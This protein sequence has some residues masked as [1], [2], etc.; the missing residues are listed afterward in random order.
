MGSQ[1]RRLDRYYDLG[2]INGDSRERSQ[3]DQVDESW[4]RVHDSKTFI[5]RV[6]LLVLPTPARRRTDT[7]KEIV[8]TSWSVHHSSK[9]REIW[10]SLASRPVRKQSSRSK[11]VLPGE[12]RAHETRS[13]AKLW[14]RMERW[15]KNWLGNGTRVSIGRLGKI[16]LSDSGRSLNSHRVSSSLQATCTCRSC[17]PLRWSHRSSTFLWFLS[18][19]TRSQRNYTSRCRSR[20]NR[21]PSTSWSARSRTRRHRRSG[22]DQETGRGETKGETK[23]R[24]I[25]NSEMV[26]RG[27]RYLGVRRQIL[28]VATFHSTLPSFARNSDWRSLV[29]RSRSERERSF[30]R[31]RSLLI[32]SQ[33][34]VI[35]YLY[36]GSWAFH[37]CMYLFEGIVESPLLAT[38][39]DCELL[40]RESHHGSYMDI[41]Y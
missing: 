26:Q 13:T 30:R 11:K 29:P 34:C 17:H 36:I 41:T 8:A 23:E 15:C 14:I 35:D 5:L 39:R 19:R 25:G 18:F 32:T 10:S 31:S 27:R 22:E 1:R 9:S 33:D 20:S 12:E 40:V 28:W 7:F 24:T 38:K 16:T 6:R 21:F 3:H 4:R 2:K 37:I